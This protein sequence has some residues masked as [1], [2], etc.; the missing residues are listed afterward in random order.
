ML[1]DVTFGQYYPTQSFIH[2]LDPR[3]KLLALI[4][5]IVMLFVANNYYSLLLCGVLLIAFIAAAKVPFKS[6]M[7]SV[8]GILFL[9]IFT[10][11]LNLFFH[12]GKTVLVEWGI[13]KIYLEGVTFTIFL[14]F[15]LFFLVMSSTIL[16]LTTT[17]VNL[18]DGIETLLKPLTYIKFPVHELALV[19]S[20]ALRFIPTLID[21]TNRI[22]SAQKARGADFENGNLFKRVKAVI[23]ILIPLL[24]SAFRRAEELGDAMDARCYSSSKT[25]TKYKQLKFSVSDLISALIFLALIAGVILLNIY[26][27]AIFPAIYPF[28]KV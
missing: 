1:K 9:L 16:T 17:P 27:E 28:I 22:I 10:A 24:I 7:R 6:V 20:I 23:P 21:E 19:M 13:I 8:K 5:Y 11:I 26:G 18:T 25:R 12:G 4:T 15:R 14:M 2:K 3:T